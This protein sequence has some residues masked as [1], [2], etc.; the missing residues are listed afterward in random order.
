[1]H[2]RGELAT[3]DIWFNQEM[4]CH[5]VAEIV[6]QHIE[7]AYTIVASGRHYFVP[8]G[9]TAFWILSESH[10][11][12][13]TYPEK[14]YVSIDLYTCTDRVKPTDTL[15]KIAK[16]LPTEKLKISRRMRGIKGR[17]GGVK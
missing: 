9:L 10:C 5:D 1:M 8:I 17:A 4:C 7:E 2:T 3:A 13:H 11:A 15:E 6:R 12:I 14:N 16:A